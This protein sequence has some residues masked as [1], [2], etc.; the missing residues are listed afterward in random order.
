MIRVGQCRSLE[1]NA[2]VIITSDQVEVLQFDERAR[3]KVTDEG[4]FEVQG[5][6]IG[7]LKV[8]ITQIV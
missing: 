3:R 5:L 4:N 7:H 2:F 6:E 8:K 1:E